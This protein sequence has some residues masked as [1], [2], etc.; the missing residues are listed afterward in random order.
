MKQFVQATEVD[1]Q[2][3]PAHE[4]EIVC[5]NCGYDLD[6]AEIAA[7]TCAECLE[8]LNLRQSTAIHATSVPAAGART[9]G[10]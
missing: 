4:V 5:H 7:D 8:P 3:Q 10:Q 1:G 9:M 2:I 6:E